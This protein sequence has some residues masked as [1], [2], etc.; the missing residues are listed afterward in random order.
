MKPHFRARNA[1][2]RGNH[3]TSNEH[4][5]SR[6]TLASDGTVLLDD[7]GLNRLPLDHGL[8]VPLHWLRVLGQFPGLVQP[9]FPHLQKWGEPG[10]S[11]DRREVQIM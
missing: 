5:P 3:D 7:S 10:L 2:A 11:Q 6:F 1:F 4:L 8:S 9:R